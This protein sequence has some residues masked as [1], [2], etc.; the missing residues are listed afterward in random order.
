MTQLKKLDHNWCKKRD[1]EREYRK[2]YDKLP[3]KKARRAHKAD[4][5]REETLYLERTQKPKD[6]DY[7]P[8]ER[9][10]P[11]ERRKTATRKVATTKHRSIEGSISYAIV[12]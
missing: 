9:R 6:G 5:K 3:V 12:V 7:K 2:E 11:R 8:N 10:S 4:A 1:K